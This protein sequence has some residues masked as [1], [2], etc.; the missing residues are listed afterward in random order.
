MNDKTSNDLNAERGFSESLARDSLR[1]KKEYRAMI[2]C[3]I[4]SATTAEQLNA[5]DLAIIEGHCASNPQLYCDLG[6]G[7][8]TTVEHVKKNPLLYRKLDSG[9]WTFVVVP[10]D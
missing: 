7:R 6:N 2:E 5:I 10:E 9:K 8:W 3:L 1:T 4:K